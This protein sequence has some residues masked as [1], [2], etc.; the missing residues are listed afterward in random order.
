MSVVKTIKDR[1]SRRA[2]LDA[3]N[4]E[5]R[6]KSLWWEQK[7]RVLQDWLAH[8]PD[9]LS[10]EGAVQLI[11]SQLERGSAHPHLRF[12]CW[13]HI[14]I[15]L[16]ALLDDEGEQ[17]VVARRGSTS[18]T[19]SNR[20]EEEGG[21]GGGG[22]DSELQGDLSQLSF[23]KRQ[24]VWLKRRQNSMAA[25]AQQVAAENEHMTFSPNVQQSQG[26]MKA[27]QMS[28][29]E[30]KMEMMAM[31]AERVVRRN[32]M[33][34]ERRRD[35][36]PVNV[37]PRETTSLSPRMLG[38]AGTP[39]NA[40]AGSGGGGARRRSTMKKPK[41]NRRCTAPNLGMQPHHVG[42]EGSDDGSLAVADQ[43]AEPALSEHPEDE[44][45][46]ALSE[47]GEASAAED[48]EQQPPFVAGSFYTKCDDRGRGHYRVRDPGLFQL[49]SMYK[50]KDRVT[51]TLGVS[52]LVG[53]IEQ[54][55]HEEQVVSAI[56]DGDRFTEETAAAW[57]L[58]NGHRFEDSK[59][60]EQRA[61]MA[62]EHEKTMASLALRRASAP[63]SAMTAAAVAQRHPP[64]SREHSP[65]GRRSPTA[66]SG[67]GAAQV[68]SGG[69]RS[70]TAASPGR[71]A[72]PVTSMS[73]TDL[74]SAVA[75]LLGAATPV[76]AHSGSSGTAPQEGGA[77]KH[78]AGAG[79]AAESARDVA[80]A[81][82][83]AVVPAMPVQQLV[84]AGGEG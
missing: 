43:E 31:D 6:R 49:T 3:L 21:G 75:P 54:P 58:L 13:K 60:R 24:E 4:E 9:E 2:L 56:F 79:R 73:A 83:A 37:P 44:P 57:W 39:T 48:P 17:P 78:A 71:H 70:P 35:K 77:V 38:P 19:S 64:S 65:Q 66:G 61:D 53:R 59:S 36:G 1:Q 82:H 23:L 74:K 27:A 72:Q 16:A 25:K 11:E 22:S 29:M 33:E 45:Q 32:S 8:Y 62:K 26:S 52:L 50:R 30:K 68:T 80:A 34:L 10:V 81:A 7:E 84:Q 47:A 46:D 63:V 40:A 20:K 15:E 67:G 14:I 41:G 42:S 51:R 76:A 69:A 12:K 5:P 55:P 18:S 28:A